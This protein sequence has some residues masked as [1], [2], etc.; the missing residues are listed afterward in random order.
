MSIIL[1][2]FDYFLYQADKKINYYES[3][4]ITYNPYNPF[5]LE[6]EFTVN[7][8]DDNKFDEIK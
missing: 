3:R 5:K 1:Q 6:A 7:V 4:V 8:V 2:K